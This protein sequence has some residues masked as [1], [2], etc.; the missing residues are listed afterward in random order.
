MGKIENIAC[1]A[2][3]SDGTVKELRLV[4]SIDMKCELWQIE[5]EKFEENATCFRET[6][7]YKALQALREYLDP[8]GCQLLCAGARPDVNPSGMSRSMGG[9]RCAYIL[10]LGK[11]ATERV[12]IFDYAEPVLVGTIQQ[13]RKYFEAWYASLRA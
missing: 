5:L 13:Q 2:L 3:L 8:K 6:D 1:R 9:G 10:H 4:V 7:L 12:D 11:Q